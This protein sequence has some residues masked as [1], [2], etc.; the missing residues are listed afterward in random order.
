MAFTLLQ[1]RAKAHRRDGLCTSCPREA[2]EG[3]KLCEEHL[4][5]HRQLKRELRADRRRAGVCTSCGERPPTKRWICQPCT[6]RYVKHQAD[7][8]ARQMRRQEVA[9]SADR[10]YRAKLLREGLCRDCRERP[11]AKARALCVPCREVRVAASL[12]R[13]LDRRAEGLCCCGRAPRQG[14]AT[15]AKCA[16]RNRRRTRLNRKQRKARGQCRQCPRRAVRASTYCLLH[17]QENTDGKR[18][19]ERRRRLLKEMKRAAA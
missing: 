16:A 15:C 5:Y 14:L 11:P 4:R 7:R 12:E 10:R 3:H 6:R 17:R 13:R 18:R 2:A 8:R 1:A 9:T 19:T